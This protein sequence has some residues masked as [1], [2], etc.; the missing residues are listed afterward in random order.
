[1]RRSAVN[2]IVGLSLA[3]C[4]AVPATHAK[5]SKDAKERAIA[6][7]LTGAKSADFDVRAMAVEGLGKAPKKRVIAVVKD[8][9][10]DQQWQVRRAVIRSLVKLKDKSWQTAISNAMLS[11]GLDAEKEVFPLLEAIG[12]KGAL[13]VMKKAFENPKMP[14]PQRYVELLAKQGGAWLLKGF[15]MGLSLK[16]KQAKEAFI[17][18]L[19]KLDLQAAGPLFKAVLLKQTAATQK[20]VLERLVD[21]QGKVD[22]SFTKKLLKAKDSEVKFRAAAVLGTSG[23]KS[24]RKLLVSAL[25]AD[26]DDKK[27]MALR[28]L[29]N[30]AGTDLK[31]HLKPFTSSDKTPADL[32]LA[33]LEI[34]AALKNE[35]LGPW[36]EKRLTGRIV[37]SI[38]VQVAAVSVYGSV[39]GKAALPVLYKLL[40]HGDIRVRKGAAKALGDL[41]RRESINNIRQALF[42]NNE[43][44]GV[45][46]ELIKALEAINSP[47]CLDVLRSEIGSPH[48]SVK[49][50]VVRALAKVRHAKTVPDLEIILRDARSMDLRRLAVRSILRL[51]PLRYVKHFTNA[52]NWMTADD[53]IGLTK[54]HEREM[55][56]HIQ[57]ALSSPR[58]ATREAGIAALKQLGSKTQSEL[59]RRMALG[60]K[61]A[62]MRLAGL[63][64]LMALEGKKGGDVY[65]ALVK[66]ADMS[67]RVEALKALG[68]LSA[69]AAQELLFK[70]TDDPDEKIRV[71]AAAALLTL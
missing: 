18:Q 54:E 29:K 68:I 9:L 6:T 8:A 49:E 65:K 10:A 20:A 38:P 25:Q 66:D 52:M 34:H 70:A 69:K 24:G 64:S 21:T 1:M 62:Q 30:I 36:L 14:Q 58:E 42:N 5:V 48:D 44:P 60:N 61:R 16:Q 15:T 46:V 43:D 11:S 26:D 4:L 17:E 19:P 13:P 33:A 67:V 37:Q 47:E 39:R 32:L 28:A 59:F 41:A 12:P 55:I 53:M 31:P 45:K 71:A 50:A 63:R 23:D 22:V 40:G 56:P 7:L 51:G 3:L 2:P 35:K 27:L 57:Q